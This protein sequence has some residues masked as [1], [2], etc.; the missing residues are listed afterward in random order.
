MK[1]MVIGLMIGL[2]IGYA[3]SAYAA[4]GDTVSAVFSSF[5][6]VV[7]GTD[8]AVDSPVLVYEGASYVRTTDIGNMLGFDVTY[9]SDS[10][11]IAFSGGQTPYPTPSPT[12]T[13][14]TVTGGTY[15]TTP[16]PSVT[17]IPSGTIDPTPTPS[18]ATTASPDPNATPAPSTDPSTTPAPP[19]APTPAPTPVPALPT[20]YQNNPNGQALY[21]QSL[22]RDSIAYMTGGCN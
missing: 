5:N 6:Y 8:K 13:P 12:S 2:T 22:P 1:K 21:C 3:A 7:N 14:T 18:T 17:S 19:V 9:K 10:R 4:V 20:Q 15:G 16:T 11:T